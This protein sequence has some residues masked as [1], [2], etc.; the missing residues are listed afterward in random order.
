IT[1]LDVP[2]SVNEI[3]THT[4][5]YNTDLETVSNHS[6]VFGAYMFSHDEVLTTFN[7]SVADTI[8]IGPQYLEENMPEH[9]FEYCT[10]ITAVD[11][12]NAY[13]ADYMFY[14]CR[15]IPEIYIRPNVTKIG[16]GAFAKNVSLTDVYYTDAFDYNT[17]RNPKTDDAGKLVSILDV[18]AIKTANLL[19]YYTVD[20]TTFILEGYKTYT[21]GGIAQN[22][23]KSNVEYLGAFAFQE[24]LISTFDVPQVS[25]YIGE[26]V[27][28][29]CR[30]ITFIYM[31]F[32]GS[33]IGNQNVIDATFGWIFGRL[34]LDGET[35]SHPKATL[36]AEGI[37]NGYDD[38]ETFNLLTDTT[39]F[40][41]IT[42]S[43]T[44][45]HT[46]TYFLP[47]GLKTVI[48]T[49]ETIVGRGAFYDCTGL[50]HIWLP[51]D[52]LKQ[53]QHEA[54]YNCTNLREM[55]I[56]NQISS[57]LENTFA[58]CASLEFI[59]VPYVGKSAS[60]NGI[61]SVFGVLFGTEEYEGSY[62]ALQLY[63]KEDKQ[64][65]STEYEYGVIR[66]YIPESLKMVI[67]PNTRMNTIPFGA[68]SNCSQIERIEISGNVRYIGAYAFF[69]C[70]SLE[71]YK[72]DEDP[73][74]PIG[75]PE[76]I[77]EIGEF[78]FSGCVSMPD[79]I[80]SPVLQKIGRY[81]FQDMTITELYVPNTTIEI[82]ENILKGCYKL[83]TL[84]VPFI[85]DRLVEPT[86][87]TEVLGHFFGTS[88]EYLENLYQYL[89]FHQYLYFDVYNDVLNEKQIAT[90]FGIPTN[91]TDIIFNNYMT[92]DIKYRQ[93]AQILLTGIYEE[94]FFEEY[95]YFAEE[96][97]VEYALPKALKNLYVTNAPHIADEACANAKELV[98]V[99]LS[100]SNELIYIGN[101]AFLNNTALENVYLPA[102]VTMDEDGERYALNKEE[103]PSTILDW[104]GDDA[105]RNCT[106]LSHI[107]LDTCSELE[108]IGSYAF[109]GSDEVRSTLSYVTIPVSVTEVGEYAF[110]YNGLTDIEI[111]NNYIGDHMFYENDELVELVV[112]TL[113]IP[114][115]VSFIGDYA[116]AECDKLEDLTLTEGLDRLGN[117]MFY[118]DDSLKEV[119]VPQSINKES[120]SCADYV[121]AECSGLEKATILNNKIGN[122]MF[123]HAA[124][125]GEE[126]TDQDSHLRVVIWDVDSIEQ[127]GTGAFM[128][129]TLL[130]YLAS[131]SDN[132]GELDESKR[133][134]LKAPTSSM[135]DAIGDK[136][137]YN[138]KAFTSIVVPGNIAT[139]GISA[140]E[141]CRGVLTISFDENGQLTDIKQ[142]AF[143][144]NWLVK[145]IEIP[146]TVEHIG[147]GALNG[148]SMLESLTLPFIGAQESINVTTEGLFGYIFAGPEYYNSYEIRQHFVNNEGDLD[149]SVVV[150][151]IPKGL[152]KVII[153]D[154]E[155]ISYGAFNG[156]A[157]L[158]EILLPDNVKHIYKNA[159]LDCSGLT[160]IEIPASV[161]TIGDSAFENCY[162]LQKITFLTE[163]D[164]NTALRTLGNRVFTNCRT[165]TE[166]TIP[167]TLQTFGSYEDAEHVG[168]EMFSGCINLQSLTLPFIGS[169]A[170]NT[171]TEDSLFGWMFGT[172]PIP[173]YKDIKNE[174]VYNTL[175]TPYDSHED[176]IA[177]AV[178][179]GKTSEDVFEYKGKYYVQGYQTRSLA[180]FMLTTAGVYKDTETG[181]IYA[182]RK[183]LGYDTVAELRAD[184]GNRLYLQ[185]DGKYYA[186][187]VVTLETSTT[188][189]DTLTE[190]QEAF[191]EDAL[192]VQD[193]GKYYVQYPT[194]LN[195]LS[196]HC[197]INN[198]YKMDNYLQITG[199]DADYINFYVAAQRYSDDA[200][201]KNYILPTALTYVNFTM[202]TVVG[203]G[204]LMRCDSLTTVNFY[205]TLTK[206]SVDASG[207]VVETIVDAAGNEITT[208]N[209]MSKTNLL[210]IHDYGFYEN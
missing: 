147:Y 135:V 200:I 43:Y 108:S 191:G 46:A 11:I 209:P 182:Y 85:A 118:N 160:H 127:L 155:V 145:E 131:V 52:S 199:N 142:N 15:N 6:I 42:Q 163:S 193:A 59:Q 115:R 81:A 203:Y 60:A 36:T 187:Y 13:I 205:E 69:N 88:K 164:G 16:A 90:L 18:D 150:T 202:E 143:K 76:T 130:D 207:N 149:D 44:N 72:K 97:G 40:Y 105:F 66:Y 206:A 28:K 73:V 138:C 54:F 24:T 124:E 23:D 26:G 178:E 91:V 179:A 125:P 141:G 93:Y 5:A 170:G 14:Q 27:I 171:G 174:W 196:D 75:F 82:G 123:A 48:I 148:E 110:A 181:T 70:A 165:I 50:D 161:E 7:S 189:F 19:T 140:F 175:D 144:D 121:F 58:K 156:C 122:Y 84:S 183:D 25:T 184:W 74:H 86:V 17:Y 32:I 204:A 31:P 41:P 113:Q 195:F 136:T 197:Y 173:F 154:D 79:M 8:V 20:D 166:L 133:G 151:Y 176:A 106:N 78:A 112:P 158:E 35:L 201:E 67:I 104:I 186:R 208:S 38:E 87:E 139:I 92:A 103:N 95:Y 114:G 83:E 9:I 109:A 198:H 99:D 120:G 56:P 55:L 100:Y 1:T 71:D 53:I 68:F 101:G 152:K 172:T 177:A 169:Q 210:E 96:L 134:I 12:Q 80:L 117:Y 22:T 102:D 63:Q 30:N 162:D 89:Q 94:E 129:C 98:N 77:L 128:N 61:D 146:E 10:S 157:S 180:D 3:G 47:V 57:I 37:D 153:A 168:G 126:L 111:L 190:L 51:Q 194:S 64:E 45:V 188:A 39:L 137:F 185:I 33:G 62:P 107:Q 21:Y 116:F 119:V 2:A 65:Q 49:K 192:Y 159:F 34:F 132:G 167:N 4:F 29:G